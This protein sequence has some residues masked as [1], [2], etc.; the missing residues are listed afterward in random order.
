MITQ[1]PRIFEF[2]KQRGESAQNY[3]DRMRSTNTRTTKHNILP[4]DGRGVRDTKV[5]GN[6]FQ[7]PAKPD[8]GR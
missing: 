1:W 2:G 3:E 8:R 7:S 6:R 5:G 4:R